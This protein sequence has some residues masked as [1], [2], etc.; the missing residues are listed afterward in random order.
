MARSFL[1][2]I[3][4]QKAENALRGGVTSVRKALGPPM[5]AEYACLGGRLPYRQRN[6]LRLFAAGSLYQGAAGWRALF[7]PS[8]AEELSSAFSGSALITSR[9]LLL[10]R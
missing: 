7:S 2:F 8:E 1:G 10:K 6:G 3:K 9:E 4:M 5:G